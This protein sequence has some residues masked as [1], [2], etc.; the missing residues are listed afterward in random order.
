[1]NMFHVV[2]Q[3]YVVPEEEY[4]PPAD[5]ITQ[6]DSRRSR[7]KEFFSSNGNATGKRTSFDKAAFKQAMTK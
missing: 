7:R 5:N 6:P 1:M 4:Q 2:V 3:V